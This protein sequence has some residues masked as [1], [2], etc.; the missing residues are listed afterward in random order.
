MRPGQR[1]FSFA[2]FA[3]DLRRGC[4]RGPDGEIDLRPKSFKVLR[5]LV[6]NAGR[7]VPKDE[8]MRA[9]WPNVIVGD[10]SL[11]RCVSDVR[12]A[13]RDRAQRIV[14]TVPRRGYL[15]AVPTS[16]TEAD[17]ASAEGPAAD[18]SGVA[19]VK[20]QPAERRQLTVMSCGVVGSPAFASRLDPED[21]RAAIAEYHRCCTEL[22]GRFGGVVAAFPG[23]RVLAYFGYPEAHENDAERA[24]RAGLALVDAVA[25]L[26]IRLFSPL[27]VRVGIASG[28]VVLGGA[29]LDAVGR[30][31]I[32]IGEAPDLAD[33]LQSAASPDAVVI[34]AST[35]HLVRSLFDYRE[36]GR[37]TLEGLAEPVPAWQVV[38]TS[39]AEKS[40][41]GVARRA[42]DAVNRP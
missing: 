22:I 8:I 2:S 19:I 13:L 15:L 38:G 12:L 10:E 40:L 3:L 42:L 6:E 24:V 7:L 9:V 20:L 21:L 25:T 39:S 29:A 23:D 16:E 14:R 31:P 30:D 33:Q 32:A 4:L 35:R 41:R 17:V 11:A 36:L 27:H 18:A 28:I 5:Y 37:V 26:D 34:A 1:L